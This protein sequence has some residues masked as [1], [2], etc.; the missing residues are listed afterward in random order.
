VAAVAVAAA[1]AAG[2]TS[3]TSVRL[4]QRNGCW[5]RETRA[6]RGTQEELGPCAKPA[7]TWSDDRLTRIVQECISQADYRWEARALAA[8]S[9]HEPLPA[10][11]SQ[12]S[13]ITTCMNEAVTADVMQ[14]ETMRQRLAELSSERDAARSDLG[15]G[16]EHLRGSTDRLVAYLGEAAREAAKRPTPTATAT[17]MSTSDGSA[18]SDT[19]LAADTGLLADAGLAADTGASAALPPAT[20]AGPSSATPTST[21]TPAPT[22]APSAAAASP[23]VT[24]AATPAS[25]QP[26]ART[27]ERVAKRLAAARRARLARTAGAAGCDVP[28]PATRAS[29]TEAPGAP[30]APAPASAS[31]G[32]GAP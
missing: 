29:A 4:S 27:K 10:Q 18:A 23:A 20:A 1:G 14:N 31:G 32:A 16:T 6:G 5:V 11:E 19:G 13:V 3:V 28:Q 15:K 21:P 8:W 25:A 12:E 7:P 26:G 24:T 17:A 22:P 30:P 2:C 9:R